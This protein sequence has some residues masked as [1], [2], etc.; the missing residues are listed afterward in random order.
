MRWKKAASRLG[1]LALLAALA[2]GSLASAGAQPIEWAP[3][4]FELAFWATP[5]TSGDRRVVTLR[6]APACA[7][8]LAVARVR[9]M[10]ALDDAAL[11]PEPAHEIDAHGHVLKTWR[12]P[13]NAIVV[14]RRG[15][16]LL[17]PLPQITGGASL[18]AIAPDGRLTPAG[19][20]DPAVAAA[21]AEPQA[22]P[23][24]PGEGEASA[25]LRCWRLID[26]ARRSE[27]LIVYR[28]PCA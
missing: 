14:G 5:Q 9:E 12:L 28:R 22:C 21:S 6:D 18:V 15:D 16:S 26:S 3:G 11:R 4:A 19:Q 27:S 8:P 1:R 10:P 24:R 20:F 17:V 25:Q 2:G 7:A 13:A 23:A